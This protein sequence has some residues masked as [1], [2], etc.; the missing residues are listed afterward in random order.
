MSG[1]TGRLRGEIIPVLVD[2]NGAVED[3]PKLEALV[4][5]SGPGIAL[6]SHKWNEITQMIRMQTIIGAIVLTGSGKSLG[7]VTILV[8]VNPVKVGASL[9]GNT[10]KVENFRLDQNPSIG[11]LIEFDQAAD[12]GKAVSSLNPCGCLWLVFL[13]KMDESQPR[14]RLSICHSVGFL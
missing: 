5:K 10:R 11:S 14:R 12:F 2:N 6:V 1:I 8:N 4:I 7:A 3:I 13:K 9:S